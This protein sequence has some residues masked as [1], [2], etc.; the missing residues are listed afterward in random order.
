MSREHTRK[1][2]LSM[3][4]YERSQGREDGAAAITRTL[5][6]LPIGGILPDEPRNLVACHGRWHPIPGVP[7][8]LPCCGRRI[9]AEGQP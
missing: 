4:H 6:Q 9:G 5:R 3:V 8:V 7:W 2:L 1:L